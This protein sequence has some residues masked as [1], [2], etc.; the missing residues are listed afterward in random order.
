MHPNEKATIST[1]V[2]GLISGTSVDGIDAALVEISGEE[3]D[4][5]IELLAGETYPYPAELRE[6]I[7]ALCAGAA[8]SMAELAL[9]DDAIAFTFAQAAQNIQNGHQAAHLI[10]SHGQ[11]V[12]HR[13]VGKWE[14]AKQNT[15]YFPLPTPR[16]PLGY[17]L[18]LGRGA[19]IAHLTGITTV[20]NFR[21]AD[22]AIG[23]HGAPL[24]PRVDAYLLSHPE[25]GRCIQNI[26]GIGNVAYIPPR[27]GD[28]LSKIRG[29]D[30]GPGNSLLDLAVQHLSA[31]A[32]TYDENGNWAASGT[33]CYPLVD[34]WL[35][36]EYFHLPP[37][38]STGRELFGLT[39]LEQCFKDAQAYQLNAADILATLTELTAASIVHSYQT[40]LPEMPQRVLLCGGGSRNL[41]L[42]Q[43]LQLLL[44]SV[45]VLTTD[46]VGLSA[47]FK[48]AIA[49]AVLAYWRNL[50][51]PG[52]L[53]TAT[54][55]PGEVLLGE[56]H[57][58]W[59]GSRE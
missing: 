43:R 37:P 28:W 55:A 59:V 32:K 20:S 56:I 45:P 26:G 15:S 22:I 30:T 14:I 11:T 42:K 54:G 7:L 57:Q 1:R 49:F 38:K 58:Y 5:K 51:I 6:R 10:G 3:L 44:A 35:K 13:P 34:Q 31:G 36:Q 2:I 29:W 39:Y 25:E 41:Y 50:G 46:E 8:I 19:L 53:P 21:A 9:I 27:H 52:N 18:Q 33:P 40:F 17:S 16:S 48:E 47:D 23:G 24:V 4:L 12:Y